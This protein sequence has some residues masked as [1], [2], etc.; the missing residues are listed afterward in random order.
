MAACV[1]DL[2]VNLFFQAPLFANVPFS[3]AIS[4]FGVELIVR[5][6]LQLGY[7]STEPTQAFIS[8]RS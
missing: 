6:S 4:H 8:R 5:P 2:L 3:E 7:L 1:F